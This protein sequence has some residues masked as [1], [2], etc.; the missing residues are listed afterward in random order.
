MRDAWWK[1]EEEDEKKKK[2]YEWGWERAREG[3]GRWMVID[4]RVVGKKPFY[5]II[6]HT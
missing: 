6:D 4:S 1:D 5:Y 3:E 2:R